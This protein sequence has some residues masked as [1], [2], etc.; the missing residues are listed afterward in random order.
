MLPSM[1]RLGAAMGRI[2]MATRD[3]LVAA[4]SGRYG[5]S[6]RKDRGRILD[7]FTAVSG[8]HRK[9]AMRLLRAARSEGRAGVRPEQRVYDEAMREA[10]IILGEASDRICGKRLRASRKARLAFLYQVPAISNLCRLRECFGGSE[11]VSATTVASDQSDLWLSRQLGLRCCWLTIGRQ[12]NCPAPLQIADERAVTLVA[13]PCPVIDP[14]HAGRDK[15]WAATSPHHSQ[16]RI[17]ADGH[18]PTRKA[19]GRPSANREPE[20][21]HDVIEPRRS[22]RPRSKHVGVE[23]FGEYAPTALGL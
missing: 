4:L 1:V 22:A 6:T 15:T 12:R 16:Q 19:G 3:E 21:M 8:L 18:Q 5:T 10:I 17:L 13:S 14:D 2:S 23:A 9:H 7:E 20:M 11:G